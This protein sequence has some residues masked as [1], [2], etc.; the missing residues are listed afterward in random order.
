ME[1]MRRP[2]RAAISWTLSIRCVI[3]ERMSNHDKTAVLFGPHQ[4]PALKVGD[5]GFC[6]V[7]C[8]VVVVTSWT[9]AK[10][11]WPRFRALE[12]HGGGSGVLVDEES[13]RAIRHESATAPKHWWGASPTAETNW[14]RALGVGQWDTPGSERLDA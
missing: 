6:L 10:I 13:A 11:P 3:M 7:R 12:T 2:T 9:D 8:C 1:A 14:R 5:R 4:A